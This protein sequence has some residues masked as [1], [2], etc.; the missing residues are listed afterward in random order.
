MSRALSLVSLST[1]LNKIFFLSFLPS[2]LF[3]FSRAVGRLVVVVVV[4]FI[5][6]LLV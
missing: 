2:F 6:F 4:L 1:G 3:L 5:L